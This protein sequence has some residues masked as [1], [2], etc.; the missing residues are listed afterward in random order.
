[1]AQNL[2]NLY[3]SESFQ[4]L[5]QVSSSTSA[6]VTTNYIA[7]GTGSIKSNFEI[8]ASYI[9]G[10]VESASYAVSASYATSASVEVTKEVSSSY[11]D[12]AGIAD[13]IS[14]SDVVGTV[15]SASYAVTASYALNV[16]PHESASY[17][18][19][20]SNADQADF[21][22]LAG[23]AT[24]SISSSFATNASTADSSTSAS[25]A[26]TASVLLGSIQ[27]AS[28]S[29]N[30]STSDL[31]DLALTANTASYVV[32]GN[33]D[34]KV[35]A[36]NVADLAN[37]VYG[38][39]VAG[40]VTSSLTAS[41]A[42]SASHALQSDSS[43]TADSATTSTSASHAVQADNSLTATSASHAV[44]ADSSLAAN[45]ATSASHALQADAADDAD[46]LIIPVKN[47]FGSTIVKGTPVYAK[48]VLGD[49]ILV[50]PASASVASTMPAIAILNEEL[51]AGTGGDAIVSGR[52]IGVNTLGF[53]AG[54]TV[55]VGAFGGYTQTKPTGSTILIQNLGVV[56]KVNETEGEGVII[57][58]GRSNDL[59]NIATSNVWIGNE[60]DVPVAIASSSLIVDNA[61]TASFLP[62]D[63]RLNVTDI[64]ASNASFTS[65]SIGF[66]QSVT[67]SAKIIGDAFI[68]LNSGTP[69][70]RYAG[71]KVE[72]SGSVSTASL[73]FDSQLNDWFYEYQG[74]DPTDY[75]VVMFG[76]EFATKGSP[77]YL[78]SNTIP[79]G[80][81]GH[82]L[83]DSS[84]V[85]NGVNVTTTLPISGSGGFIG[86]LTGNADTA[87]TASNVDYA[88][89]S[90]KPTLISSSAQVDLSLAFG[91]AATATS[92]SHALQA[93][94]S[95]TASF[96]TY[97]TASTSASHAL[98]AD[99][100][101]TAS[102]ATYATASTSASHAVQ[103]DASLTSTSASYAP[104][105]VSDN[106]T[107]TGNNTFDGQVNGGVTALTITSNTASMDMQDGN[108]FTV[109]L[110][111]A[112]D[113]H[114][115]VA[116]ITAGQTITLVVTNNATA[117]GTLSF[118]PEYKFA[119]GTAP[120]V[121]A[122]I[123][124]KDVLT[125]VTTDTS[126]IFG[127]SLLN[128]S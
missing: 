92:A 84:I 116:N 104:T 20:A 56:G 65:A 18:A 46:D 11:A 88:N 75:G 126:N 122:T 1:M 69:T 101:L 117:A 71:I 72:D 119:G 106:H 123:N 120:V 77:T 89:V 33:V 62:S 95:L 15:T 28:Y 26:A 109:T 30:S 64:T 73:Q 93:D 8:T 94:S 118:A 25:Y 49:Q 23:A 51:T 38:Y 114:L 31:A 32:A 21:A 12:V 86:D 97:A 2:L 41:I 42:T 96:A 45:T 80:D 37:L 103:A 125:F 82:H 83:N 66:L 81:G 108:F 63:T 13:A 34:G 67:G 7:D 107:F 124:A 90:S 50:A 68:I 3:I 22:D 57:G 110:Q 55:Y 60:D 79:K 112:T 121:T 70:E 115:D 6:S 40:A 9:Q 85:D 61:S 10:L 4:S 43:L 36:A 48:G 127:T 14:G 128:F 35:A 27:S 105:N 24:S 58:S 76:P 39:N 59:P 54:E 111:N 5:L 53:T 44:Q 98:Q 102:F 91:T 17:A 19:S 52:I 16:T 99:N 113:T 100:A 78:T 87:T 74:D 47:D 29:T